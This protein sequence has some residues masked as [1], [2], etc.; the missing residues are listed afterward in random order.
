MYGFFPK[1][2]R[3]CHEWT[4]GRIELLYINQY[5]IKDSKTRWKNLAKRNLPERCAITITIV[6]TM[7]ILNYILRKCTGGYKLPKSQEKSTI[8]LFVE[9]EKEVET[10]IQRERERIYSQYIGMAFGIEKMFH[11]NNEK[12]KTTRVGRNRTTKSWKN[13]NARRKG[14]LQNTWEH[15]KWTTL[16]LRR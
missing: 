9:N 6:I 1:E 10:L 5:I 16:D 12:R 2:Q 8:K 4:W 15:W 11:V 13:Q 3:G 14:K 7:M